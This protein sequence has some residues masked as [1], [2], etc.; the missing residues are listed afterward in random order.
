MLKACFADI[1]NKDATIIGTKF[2]GYQAWP[3]PRY[4]SWITPCVIHITRNPYDVVLSMI[5]KDDG[6]QCATA[7]VIED[8][9]HQWLSAWNH[10]IAHADDSDF[11]HVLYDDLY[12]GTRASRRHI[13]DFLGVD[14]FSLDSFKDVHSRSIADR[15]AAAGLEP[16]LCR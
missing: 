16:A 14:D 5:K 3:A 4:P 15:Y 10:A 9:I 7:A 2:L 8:A 13:A 11:C 12:S 1:F 6:N